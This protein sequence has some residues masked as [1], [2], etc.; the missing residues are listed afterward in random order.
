M[1]RTI[2]TAFNECTLPGAL[3]PVVPLGNAQRAE[4]HRQ[5]AKAAARG[6]DRKSNPFGNDENAPEHTGESHE[7]WAERREAWDQGHDVQSGTPSPHA[8]SSLQSWR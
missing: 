4:L 5:G 1:S 3:L 2:R 6:D 8:R 7:D